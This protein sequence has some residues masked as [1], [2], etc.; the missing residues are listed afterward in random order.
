M[1]NGRFGNDGAGI[2]AFG[3]R[4]GVEVRGDSGG[5]NGSV[6]GVGDAGTNG[7]GPEVTIGTI[8]SVFGSAG[9]FDSTV[10][11]GAGRLWGAA[12][13]GIAFAVSDFGG[14]DA[15]GKKSGG[16]AAGSAPP[17]VLTPDDEPNVPLA[18]RASGA[19]L[20]ATE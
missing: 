4:F 13:G 12:A 15:F 18:A 9:A 8:G 3:G 14:G 20:P 1:D 5:D 16:G 6:A 11:R 7:C 19:G 2:A 10:I 17:A